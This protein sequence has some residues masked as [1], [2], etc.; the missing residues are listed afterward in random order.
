MEVFTM[1]V[2]NFLVANWDSV[3]VVVVAI[4]GAIV[5]IKRGETAF[6]KR[7]LFGLVTKAEMEFSGGTG[8]LKKAKVVEWI[9]DKLPAI[10]RFIITQSDI[11]KMIEDVLEYAKEKW[12]SDEGL[13][14]LVVKSVT[15][16]Q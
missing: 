7:I 12:S 9:Y 15:N 10:L 8:E 16:D 1:N 4:V 2:L 14:K 13:G 5:L 11:D 3:L 6:L